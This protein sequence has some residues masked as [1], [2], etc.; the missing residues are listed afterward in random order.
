M[1]R[2]T[3]IRRAITDWKRNLVNRREVDR[4]QS[5]INAGGPCQTLKL[6]PLV[7][8]RSARVPGSSI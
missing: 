3:V 8:D 5:D 1:P 4:R 6:L 2:K 7:A